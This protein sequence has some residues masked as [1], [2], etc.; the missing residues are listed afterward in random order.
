MAPLFANN[1]SKTIRKNTK[2]E[3]IWKTKNKNISSPNPKL[4]ERSNKIPR[5]CIMLPK[6]N[7]TTS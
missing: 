7:K 4:L 6:R 2:L 1:K 5:P 3:T